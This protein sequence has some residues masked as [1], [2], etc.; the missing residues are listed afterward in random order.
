[1]WQF[2]ICG[3]DW[4]VE[5]L[6][7]YANASTL[8]VYFRPSTQDMFFPG[9]RGRVKRL[10]MNQSDQV[11]NDC[12]KDISLDD[13]GGFHTI[14][15][16]GY[17]KSTTTKMNCTITYTTQRSKYIRVWAYAFQSDD[18]DRFI[19]TGSESDGQSN[20]VVYLSGD[21]SGTVG[22]ALGNLQVTWSFTTGKPY[23][24]YQVVQAYNDSTLPSPAENSCPN[25]GQLIDMTATN[26]ATFSAIPNPFNSTY[27]YLAD[28]NCSWQFGN[29][30]ANHQ[31]VLTLSA[32]TEK[33][34]DPLRVFGLKETPEATYTKIV[35][36]HDLYAQTVYYASKEIELK[37]L[38]DSTEQFTMM[39]GYVEA[40]DCSCPQ[41]LI[42]LNAGDKANI[43]FGRGRTY[44]RPAFCN[45]TII[46]N[47][48][49]LVYL[50]GQVDTDILNDRLTYMDTINNKYLF[51]G[52]NSDYTDADSFSITF[53]AEDLNLTQPFNGY[54]YN[55]STTKLNMQMIYKE[56]C[57][58]EMIDLHA[59][60]LLK[61]FDAV[62]YSL[63][64]TNCNTVAIRAFLFGLPSGYYLNLYDGDFDTGRPITPSYSTNDPM[65]IATNLL[66]VRIVR[67]DRNVDRF[68]SIFTINPDT[69]IVFGPKFSFSTPFNMTNRVNKTTLLYCDPIGPDGTYGI[70]VS[71]S[72]DSIFE[73]YRGASLRDQ[74]RIYGGV[75]KCNQ[76]VTS[77]IVPTFIFGRFI[78]FQSVSS[79]LTG[80]FYCQQREYWQDGSDMTS[81]VLMAP[82]YL[83]NPIPSTPNN[84]TF[85]LPSQQT[86]QK[87]A[88]TFLNNIPS[89]SSLIVLVDDGNGTKS[90]K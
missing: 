40:I 22:W 32:Y 89:N 88:V 47:R 19:W 26:S 23:R 31:L 35:G 57:I 1:M 69:A 50:D 86:L 64:A 78:T 4:K 16:D 13:W 9:Y 53:E 10:K 42:Q 21:M 70:G 90:T 80:E 36:P 58:E 67:L 44:C 85:I 37:L 59:D 60:M 8:Y 11:F 20:F 54:S 27:G 62:V 3:D 49:Q 43:R 73:L 71:T 63:N 77:T 38:S 46:S 66:A 55:F 24:F 28:T 82:T 14:I 12:S 7:N 61:P 41:A 87:I 79:I 84:Y 65:T 52:Y 75:S 34:C 5:Q 81:G 2:Q 56:L 17:P 33:C 25:S 72:E 74:D 45:T 15:S 51:N 48:N 29:L 68:H 6:T 30:P 76:S 83:S 18:A 39:S